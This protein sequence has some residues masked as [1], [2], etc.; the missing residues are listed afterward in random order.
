MKLFHHNCHAN[1]YFHILY[2]C[3]IFVLLGVS[4]IGFS[5]AESLMKFDKITY[6][7]AEMMGPPQE[8]TINADGEVR[9]ESHSNASMLDTQEI[10]YYETRLSGSEVEMLDH[11]LDKPSFQSLPDHWGRI[12]AGDR[13]RRV[14]VTSQSTTIEK[15]TGTTEPVNP[16]L[17]RFIDLLDQIVTRAMRY[18][19]RTLQIRVSRVVLDES[20]TL[21]LDF[22]LIGGGT[23]GMNIVNPVTLAGGAGLSVRGWPDKSPSEFQVGEVFGFNVDKIAEARTQP[24]DAVIETLTQIAPGEV[25]S[26]STSVRLFVPAPQTYLI[27]LVYQNTTEYPE[28][29]DVLIGELFSKNIKLAV[30]AIKR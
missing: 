6:T 5:H 2:C 29:P 4:T 16:G 27:Q 26:F 14:I 1:R 22:E 20:G 11:S 9:Y 21:I 13:Y 19:K 7:V 17:T 30:P 25:R 12:A 3:S 15:V 28:R 24:E 8:L 10:G 23:E 18:P